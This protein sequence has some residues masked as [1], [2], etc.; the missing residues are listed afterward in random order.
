MQRMK[1][2]IMMDTIHEVITY[3]LYVV[4]LTAAANTSKDNRAF[5]FHRSLSDVFL[6]QGDPLFEG[7]RPSNRRNNEFHVQ[8]KYCTNS[9]LKLPLKHSS[10]F[11]KLLLILFTYYAYFIK[12]VKENL[13]LKSILLLS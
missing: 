12:I 7:V 13:G 5:P 2:K 3:V 8:H 4:L 1:H 9:L 11:L 6:T 10:L